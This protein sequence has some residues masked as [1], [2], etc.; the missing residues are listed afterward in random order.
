MEVLTIVQEA[1]QAR[2]DRLQL[3]CYVRANL[4]MLNQWSSKL[5]QERVDNV[6]VWLSLEPE[7]GLPGGDDVK[8]KTKP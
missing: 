1:L 4:L 2:Q 3:Q 7:Q 5:N 8:A 6:N